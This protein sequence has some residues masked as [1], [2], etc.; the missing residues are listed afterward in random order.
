MFCVNVYQ[1]VPNNKFVGAQRADPQ[2]SGKRGFWGALDLK[3]KGFYM[4][5]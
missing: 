1:G 3:G 4:I 2:R 5:L